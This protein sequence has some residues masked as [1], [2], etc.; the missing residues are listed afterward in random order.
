MKREIKAIKGFDKDLKC[1][2]FQ[3]EVG[4]TYTID[5]TIDICHNGFH[6][7][8]TDANPFKVFL[9]YP[10]ATSRYCEVIISGEVQTEDGKVCGSEITIVAEIGVDD[11]IIAYEEWI[12]EREETKPRNHKT[13][14]MSSSS[15]IAYYGVATNKGNYSSASTFGNRSSASNTGHTSNSSTIGNRSSASNTG[16]YSRAYSNGNGSISSNTGQMS[17]A[18]NSGELSIA[19]N[20]G[21]NSIARNSGNQGS[22]INNGDYGSAEVSGCSSVAAAFGDESRVRGAIGC[23]L[24]LTERG[25]W[26]FK[27]HCTRIINVKAVIVDG[28][29][30]KADTWY[31]LKDGIL[32]ECQELE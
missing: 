5:G 19:C 26:D 6:A 3:Y 13:S 4:K 32:T 17:I 14:D 16:D 23:A 15:D 11:I 1:R 18:N 21:G 12:K 7:I 8:P 30:V 10:I 28:V 25:G 2:G 27:N 31:T 22:A 24:F 29:N 9:Y 20:A